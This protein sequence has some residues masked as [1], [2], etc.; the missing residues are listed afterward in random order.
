MLDKILRSLSDDR[1][2]EWE[3][4]QDAHDQHPGYRATD[5][6][7]E[8]DGA[9]VN[10]DAPHG[11]T[12]G[13][14]ATLGDLAETPAL[15]E[16]ARIPIAFELDLG[17]YLARTTGSGSCHECGT[18]GLEQTS[19][20]DLVLDAAARQLAGQVDR[21][22]RKGVTDKAQQ[23]VAEL[24]KAGVAGVVEG[25]LTELLDGQFQ[26][27]DRWGEPTGEPRTMRSEIEAQVAALL[28]EKVIDPK[29]T[30]GGFAG[31]KPKLTRIEW[32]IRAAVAGEVTKQVTAAV[33]EAKEQV[34]ATVSGV[35]AEEI[36]KA[37]KAALR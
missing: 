1:R 33:A 22:A 10:P 15:P 26:P 35:A 23:Q 6:G 11:D 28:T 24:L 13:F 32:A 20:E 31:D 12:E 29:D 4:F 34:L 18:P 2:A 14:H 36:T 17:P 19:L 8:C 9:A 25:K 3:A 37:V 30:R 7:A 21:E 16:L 5:D 27:M